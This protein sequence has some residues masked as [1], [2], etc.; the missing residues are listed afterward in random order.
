MRHPALPADQRDVSA[1][2][3]LLAAVA[4]SLVVLAPAFAQ[5]APPLDPYFAQQ[6]ALARES[7]LGALTAWQQSTGAGAV[8]AVLDT[9]ADLTHPDLD[10]ALWT[11]PGE[12]PGNGIDDDHDG[13]VDDVHGVDLVN[14]DGDP[15]D[16]EGHG[17]HVAGIIA[18]R[19]G[20]GIG[21]AGL[22][23]GAQLMI[24][25]VLDAHRSGTAAG[26]AEGIRYALAHGATIINTSVNGDGTSR[27]LQDALRQADAAGALVVASAGNDGRDIDQDPSYPASYADPSIVS[28]ASESQGGMLSS[29]S[30]YGA[31]SVD[32]AAPGENILSTASTGDYELRS[33][34]SMAAPFV[35]ATLA[36]MKSLRPELGGAALKAALLAGATPDGNLEGEVASGSLSAIGALNALTGAAAPAPISIALGGADRAS[37]GAVVHWSLAG[38]SADVATVRVYVDGRAALT[39]AAGATSLR[40]RARP[41]LHR[42]RVVAYDGE[43]QPTVLAQADGLFRVRNADW[44]RSVRKLRA[45]ARAKHRAVKKR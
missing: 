10:G 12:I 24:V 29:F 5:A 21:G 36:L 15:T 39:A 38:D 41:G 22:A 13:Y 45:T 1:G 35:S 32:I 42:L 8:V 2:R 7:S 26:L 40:L 16:D 28:V 44:R 4:A 23:P 31:Q 34:T 25:K 3:H 9:G 18:A 14:N 27:P 19:A 17:T 30:N 6:W 37:R 43:E 33:G 20:N 11:N